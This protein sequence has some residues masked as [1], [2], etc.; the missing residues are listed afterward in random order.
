MFNFTDIKKSI[1]TIKGNK[2]FEIRILTKDKKTYS[3]YFKNVNIL[4]EELKRLSKY[5]LRNPQFYFTL[6]EIDEA[7]YSREQ[8][9]K[10][11]Y[12]SSTTKDNEITKY[13]WLFIDLDPKRPS[14]ISS[15]S[16][17]LSKALDKQTEVYLF[18]LKN[19]FSEP[20]IAESGNG[21][22]LL[23]K[24]DLPNTEENKDILKRF[25]EYLDLRFSDNMVEIDKSVFNPARICKLYGTLAQKGANTS[26]R[27]HRFAKIGNYEYGKTNS[28]TL[29]KKVADM[30]PV[31]EIER[32]YNKTGSFDLDEFFKKHSIGIKDIVNDK[33]GTKYILESCPFDSSHD[34]DSPAVFRLSNGA[35]GFKCFHNSCSNNGWKEFRRYYEPNYEEYT[36][37]PY[38]QNKQEK[39]NKT[40]TNQNQTFEKTLFNTKEIARIDVEKSEKTLTNIKE[41][42]K[43]LGGFTY[44]C[45]TLWASQ[46]NGGKTTLLTM[47]TREFIKQGR[48]IFYFN[49][50]QTKENFLNNLILLNSPKDKIRKKEYKSTGIYDRYVDDET[51]ENARSFYDDNLYIYNNEAPRNINSLITSMEEARYKIGVK[52]FIIDNLMQIDIEESENQFRE[53]ERLAE[54]LRTFAINTKSNVHLVAHSRKTSGNQ[55]RLTLFDIAG[56]QNIANKSYNIVTITRID[57]INKTQDEYEKLKKDLLNEGYD[58]EETDGVLEVVK[59]KYSL[60]RSGLVGLRYDPEQGTY[61]ELPKL[62]KEEIEIRQ[63]E[64]EKFKNHRIS[65]RPKERKYYD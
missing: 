55:I 38:I 39:N 41:L 31:T 18:L 34:K 62:D 25:L 61:I 47:L 29:I 58:I 40:L 22:H 11:L 57:Q 33:S 12:S 15:N 2:L 49:G 52:E 20:I 27:P 4:I 17:E 45:V 37:N 32:N 44:D 53:Q 26:D 1:E 64:I 7:C 5:N 10:I 59:Y 21:C 54:K 3:G 23:Y 51:Y 56:S 9:D 36:I 28:F 46:T 63:A 60:G 13:E 65:K 43:M 35:L 19:G 24:I 50:E 14:D 16:V 8:H 48:K 30:Y 42:D 6:N